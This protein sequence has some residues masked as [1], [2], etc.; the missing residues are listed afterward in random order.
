M[1]NKKIIIAGGSGF[2]GQYF[3]NYFE[4]EN[5]IIILTRKKFQS[6][7]NANKD[8]LKNTSARLVE[9]DGKSEGEWIKELDGADILINLTGKSVN[10]RYT[11]KNKKEILDSRT[12]ATNIL[13]F[14]IQQCIHAPKLWI[15]AASA[16]IY[17]NATDRPQDE[18]TGEYEN[19]FSVQVCKKWEETFYGQ[20]TPATRKIALRMAIVLGDGG[21]MV[22]YLNLLKFGLGGRQGSGKQMYSWI[23]IE[24]VARCVEWISN[25]EEI[26]G[27]YNCAAPNPVNNELFMQKLRKSTGHKFGF[28]AEAWMLKIGAVIIGTETELILKSRWVIPS[29]LLDSG[30]QFKFPEIENAFCNLVE[31]L[32]GKAYHLF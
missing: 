8:H 24:D 18:Y 1:K 7:N 31:Q 19:D 5:E 20:S 32:P 14:A 25:H 23:H 6:N 12:H 10:C 9:W 13:G 3:S 21:V 15:N 29:K 2:I 16:T 22:P 27:T 11:S 30:F 4:N 26:A 17:R 28:P